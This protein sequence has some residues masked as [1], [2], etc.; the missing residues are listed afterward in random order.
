MSAVPCAEDALRVEPHQLTDDP[1]IS[2]ETDLSTGV[3]QP[4]EVV[5]SWA[6]FG[7][8][9]AAVLFGPWLFGAWEMWWFWLFAL[10]LFA[11]ALL[12]AL[13]LL[14]RAA[15]PPT[16]AAEAGPGALV[17]LL[18]A[19]TPLPFLC[20][21]LVRALQAE[22]MMDAERSFL[23]FFLPFLIS[24]QILYGFD[25]VQRRAMAAAVFLNLLILGLYGLVN[26][27]ITN[28]TRVL[29]APGYPQYIEESRATGSYFCP[30]HFAGIMELA[31]CAALAV[32]MTRRNGSRRKL[33]GALVA[34]VALVGVVL[35]RSRG[36]GLTVVVIVGACLAWGF[37]QW[38]PDVRWWLRAAAGLVA[39]LALVVFVHAGSRYVTRFK[40][41]F[42][43]DDIGQRPA[44]ERLEALRHRLR[45]TSRGYM[46][47]GA[48]RAWQDA[49][50][51]GIGAGMHPNL[52]PHY[53][54]SDDGDR[55]LGRWPRY[56][57]GDYY[58]FEVHNDWLQLLEEYGAV[59]FAL[60]LIPLA[61]A[62]AILIGGLRRETRQC[63]AADWGTV[64]GSPHEYVLAGLLACV[65]MAF[66]SLGDFNLQMPATTWVLAVFVSLPIAEMA[67]DVDRRSAL[68]PHPHPITPG[69]SST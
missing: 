56:V 22:V 60:C 34:A 61:A 11:G 57:Y 20:Y 44:E 13:R 59:G 32:L 49:P 66:H 5:L 51:F 45:T 18:A 39:L 4:V 7:F 10:C 30:D 54:A 17:R 36:G 3:R 41:Y 33:L 27:G 14:L 58:S 29:W 37:S 31:L 23:L 15:S 28:S 35:S 63:R 6:Q 69:P 21:A 40:S 38:P 68:R 53:A 65:C 8:M 24:I 48:F 25:V 55:E 2:S 62:C 52:W 43:W 47:A 1:G 46:Y 26:H 19:I 12:F 67:A 16:R 64:R 50:I 42:S 9:S